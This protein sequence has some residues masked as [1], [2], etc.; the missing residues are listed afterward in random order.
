MSRDNDCVETLHTHVGVCMR[1]GYANGRADVLDEVEDAIQRLV[2]EIEGASG[3]HTGAYR[4]GLATA[5][6]KVR[7]KR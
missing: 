5:I 3:S 4:I 2:A 6:E 1:A 7:D